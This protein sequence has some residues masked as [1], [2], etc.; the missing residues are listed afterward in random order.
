MGFCWIKVKLP[1]CNEI[2]QETLTNR[3]SNLEILLHSFLVIYQQKVKQTKKKQTNT[4][5]KVKFLV[6][7]FP[8]K[9]QIVSHLVTFQR[10]LQIWSHL[11]KQ[12]FM[13]NFIFVWCYLPNSW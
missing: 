4:A 12:F 9:L 6:E 3:K 5:Q 11:L 8:S 10:K 13:E 2:Y 1:K 7:G